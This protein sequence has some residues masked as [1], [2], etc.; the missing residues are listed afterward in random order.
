MW[1]C[2]RKQPSHDDEV[3]FRSLTHATD[4]TGDDVALFL[5]DSKEAAHN[6]SQIQSGNHYDASMEANAAAFP[7]LLDSHSIRALKLD[8]DRPGNQPQQPTGSASRSSRDT[9]DF[10]KT[11]LTT[12]SGDGSALRSPSGE[13]LTDVPAPLVMRAQNTIELPG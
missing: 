7:Q 1:Y 5:M 11:P 13:E 9:F 3:K 8:T 12:N 10:I 6:P 2:R 4:N